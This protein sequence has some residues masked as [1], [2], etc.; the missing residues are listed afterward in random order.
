M[1]AGELEQLT[2]LLWPDSQEGADHQVYWLLDGARDPGISRAVRYGSLRFWCLYSGQL[3]PRLRA[4]APYLVQLTRG[5]P[6]T[7]ELLE[8]GWGNAWGIF[9]VAPASLAMSRVRLHFKK[10]LRVRTEDGR[11][12]LFRFYDPRVLS[13]FLPTCTDAE[14]TQFLGPMTSLF[15][16][17]EQG[18]AYRLFD[19]ADQTLR[20]TSGRLSGP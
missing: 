9:I 8:R 6:A 11:R 13:I 1:N 20:I 12:L 17:S 3:T 19:R 10:F 2:A 4:A 16:E 14:F 7:L 18:T 15:V 5:S